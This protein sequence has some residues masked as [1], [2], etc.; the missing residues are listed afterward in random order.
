MAG[1]GGD[2]DLPETVEVEGTIKYKGEPLKGGLVTF[3]PKAG[4]KPGIGELRE[5]GTFSISTYE[6]GDGA[7]LGEHVV[8]VE[9]F[10]GQAGTDVGLPG[11]EA[12]ESSPIPT[13]YASADSSPLRFTV[14]KESKPADFSLED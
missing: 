4:R 10:A 13:K 5:D 14:E 6:P 11:A 7:E 12:P 2:S 8:T 9:V 3:H 1:C